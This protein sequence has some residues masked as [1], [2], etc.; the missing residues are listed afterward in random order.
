MQQLMKYSVINFLHFIQY[1]INL[2][3]AGMFYLKKCILIISASDTV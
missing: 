1:I 2:C 3:M